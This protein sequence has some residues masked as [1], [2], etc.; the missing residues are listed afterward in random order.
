MLEETERTG[1]CAHLGNLRESQ[2]QN[3]KDDL[4]NT[5]GLTAA[6]HYNRSLQSARQDRVQSGF[7]NRSH[8]KS[9][10]N[11]LSF[12]QCV[13][14]QVRGR[15]GGCA[16]PVWWGSG[17]TATSSPIYIFTVSLLELSV[18]VVFNFACRYLC[19]T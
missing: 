15:W 2:L 19:L 3:I 10:L 14:C 9:T 4:R 18:K 12:K 13:P 17:G 8:E 5:D 1:R 7:K 11:Q 16:S 6:V